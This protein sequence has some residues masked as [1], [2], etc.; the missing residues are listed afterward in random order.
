MSAIVVCVYI[1]PLPANFTLWLASCRS[2]PGIDWLLVSDSAVDYS[3]LPVNVRLRQ[4]TL[5]SLQRFFSA[6]VGFEVALT[7]PYKLNDF[8]PLF[9]ELIEDIERYDY[10]GFCDL[11]VQFGQLAPF[12]QRTFGQYDM[13]L[14]EGHLR[15]IKNDLRINRSYRDIVLPRSWRD[16][17]RDPVNFGMDEHQ[18]INKVFKAAN[19]NTFQNSALIADIDPHFRQF[20]L[21]PQHRNYHT[22][23]FAFEDGKVFREFRF[24]GRYGRDEFLYIHFQKRNLRDKTDGHGESFFISPFGFLPRKPGRSDR[25]T[26]AAVNPWHL[27]NRKELERILRMRARMVLR[28]DDLYSSIRAPAHAGV[29]Q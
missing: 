27:P 18:G 17:L 9:F 7:N 3:K 4:E 14:S 29:K 2:N 21:L 28:G 11:D 19:L 23:A 22:Q 1:G 25:D 10:W 5:G 13:I 16:I 15:F 24:C 6:R 12:C 8:K 20:R 26:I